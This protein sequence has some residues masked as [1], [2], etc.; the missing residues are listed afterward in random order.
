MVPQRPRREPDCSPGDHAE[1]AGHIAA[2]DLVTARDVP[3]V[4][5][6]DACPQCQ[7]ALPSA[8]LVDLLVEVVDYIGEFSGS[9]SVGITSNL[10]NA[11]V[12]TIDSI[13]FNSIEVQNSF[14]TLSLAFQMIVVES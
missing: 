6:G 1:E 14:C 8:T 10:S 5:D 11:C 4:L 3:R 7:G 9:A 2:D 13:V 12:A